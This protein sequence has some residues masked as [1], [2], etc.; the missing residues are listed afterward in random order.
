MLFKRKADIGD[1]RE[2][3]PRRPEVPLARQAMQY[4]LLNRE[5]YVAAIVPK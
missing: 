3:P 2:N 5:Y 1:F 4:S